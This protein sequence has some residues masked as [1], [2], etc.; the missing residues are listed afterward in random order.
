MRM[1][2]VVIATWVANDGQA[3]RIGQILEEL[4]PGNRAEPKMIQFQAHVSD[5]D[6]NTFIL[7]EHYT[8]ASGYQDHRNSE[9]FQTRVLGE[10]IPNLARREV[11]TM[12]TFGD[13]QFA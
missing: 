6:P 8:D 12:Q 7:Y 1:G 9:P 2:F 10:A 4:T 5:E 3:Q 13:V 11:T